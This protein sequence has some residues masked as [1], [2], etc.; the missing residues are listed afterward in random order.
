MIE[1]ISQAIDEVDYLAVILS[2]RSVGSSWV[3]QELEQAM[4]SQLDIGTVRVLPLLMKKCDLPSF[5]RG[6]LYADFTDPIN[7]RDSLLQ[8]LRTLGAET[9]E[10]ALFFRLERRF[11]S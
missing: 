8:L 7:Y 11:E 5:L 6:K 10:M 3:R 1:K 2:P 4:T 9:N